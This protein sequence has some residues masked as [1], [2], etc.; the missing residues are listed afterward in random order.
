MND[1]GEYME[2]TVYKRVREISPFSN[3]FEKLIHE[4]YRAGDDRQ[5]IERLYRSIDFVHRNGDILDLRMKF[6]EKNGALYRTNRGIPGV[7]QFPDLTLSY[8]FFFPD[9]WMSAL[10]PKELVMDKDDYICVEIPAKDIF[11]RFRQIEA[12][13]KNRSGWKETSVYQ[14]FY[15]G[16]AIYPALLKFLS[17]DDVLQIVVEHIYYQKDKPY[18]TVAKEDITTQRKEIAEQL[19]IPHWA[20]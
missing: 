1:M 14:A 17:E 13:N 11:E 4:L 7:E 15:K 16:D 6:L 2:V 8:K 20:N 18:R 10:K 5:E 9:F 19:F 12:C 3:G